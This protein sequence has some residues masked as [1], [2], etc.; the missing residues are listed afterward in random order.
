MHS[1]NNIFNKFAKT[2][3][4]EICT[5]IHTI[6]K[7]WTDIVGEAI[8]GHT[9]PDII[10]GKMLILTVDTPQWMHHIGFYKEDI[11]V[12]LEPYGINEIRFRLGRLPESHHIIQRKDEPILSADDSKYLEDTLKGITDKELKET[13][14]KLLTHGLT[15]GKTRV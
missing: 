10:K 8:A 14:R 5:R 11:T 15:R 4:L 6:R 1:F 7:Q 3:G 2:I 13:L 9:H 12:K